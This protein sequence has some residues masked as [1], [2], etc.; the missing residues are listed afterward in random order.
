MTASDLARLESAKALRP[1]PAT[2]ALLGFYHVT[3]DALTGKRGVEARLRRDLLRQRQVAL[4][5]AMG[6][7]KTSVIEYV[8]GP[9]GEGSANENSRVFLPI[10]FPVRDE[11]M[12]LLTDPGEFVEQLGD[13]I[14]DAAE[15]NFAG[16]RTFTR[17]KPRTRSRSSRKT[18]VAPSV[19]DPT[20]GLQLR[21]EL[22]REVVD[23][24]SGDRPS[25]RDRLAEL[26]GVL[27][28]VRDRGLEP[29]LVFDDLDQWLGSGG[30]ARDART[31]FWR[32]VPRILA[33]SLS[34]AA[35]LAVQPDALD[36]T[37]EP[38][39]D[40]VRPIVLPRVPDA[41]GLGRVLDRRIG[42]ELGPGHDRTTVVTAD[43]LQELFEYYRQGSGSIR[44][45]V[46]RPLELALD[47][48]LDAG[49]TGPVTAAG[50][51]D[52]LG[53]SPGRAAPPPRL[54]AGPSRR[55]GDRGTPPR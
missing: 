23:A 51:R 25:S 14:R 12:A 4:V 2:P 9:E 53:L 44:L 19:I 55:A 32:Q 40:V 39:R 21:L 41:S 16:D 5:G 1:R 20:T 6:S 43:A 30:E 7:G 45:D 17:P 8:L 15:R 50:L 37:F 33:E 47:A 11:R 13:V 54:P 31:R 10:V 24:L 29:V 42:F 18:I 34:V 46:L 49:D 48:A 22:A 26:R 27:Q 35:V 38:A 36:E 28:L 52:V 3:F